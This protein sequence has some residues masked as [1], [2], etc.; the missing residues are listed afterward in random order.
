[1][2]SIMQIFNENT[3]IGRFIRIY[4]ITL[5]EKNGKRTLYIANPIPVANFLFV[6]NVFNRL[7]TIDNV[8]VG[9]GDNGTYE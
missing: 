2:N 6:R 3:T 1:M 8:I 4:D 5:E 9:D 7:T